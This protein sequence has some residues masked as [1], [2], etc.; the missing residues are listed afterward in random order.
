[1]VKNL[2]GI[3]VFTLSQLAHSAIP[4]KLISVEQALRL[5]AEERVS[6][7]RKIGPKSYRDLHAIAF[8]PSRNY[9]I[10][11]RAVISMAWLGGAESIVDLE[12]A[13][14]NEE[15]YMRDAGLKGLEKINQTKAVIWAKKLLSDPALI[16]RSAAVQVIHDLHDKTAESIL[17]EKL[18][19]P[20]NFRGEQSLFIRRQILSALVDLASKGTQDKFAKLLNDKDKSLHLVAV[21]G[22][23]R[24]A[25]ERKDE[26]PRRSLELWRKQYAKNQ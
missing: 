25:G 11:W 19:A 5:P 1:M 20:E 15:W 23:E 7:L 3:F 18:N 16:V 9:D 21:E 14:D 6:L 22:L 4:K 24:A 2:A 26:N 10:R 13:L 12:R 17:W 8:D